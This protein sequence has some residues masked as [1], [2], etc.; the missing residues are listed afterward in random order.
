MFS[1]IICVGLVKPHETCTSI[2]NRYAGFR[3]KY[4]VHRGMYLDVKARHCAFTFLATEHD[5]AKIR[6]LVGE[7]RQ[8]SDGTDGGVSDEGEERGER[9]TEAE[10]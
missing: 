4:Q 5:G 7:E 9:E 1:N 3:V 10:S 2:R 6:S 8:G